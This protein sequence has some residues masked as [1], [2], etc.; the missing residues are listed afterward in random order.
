MALSGEDHEVLRAM[1][2]DFREELKEDFKEQIT[3]TVEPIKETLINHIKHDEKN[4]R[5][6]NESLDELKEGQTGL[7]SD[8]RIGRLVGGAAYAAGIGI[9]V[10]YAKGFL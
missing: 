8:M 3:L 1:F 2:K 6:V 4:D 7:K 5:S 9:V 10:S